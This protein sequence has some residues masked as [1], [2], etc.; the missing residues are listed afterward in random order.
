VLSKQEHNSTSP[1]FI[2][3][4][5]DILYNL[6]C[7]RRQIVGSNDFAMNICKYKQ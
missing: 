6:C 5:A 4:L 1:K 2:N 7:P 3:T